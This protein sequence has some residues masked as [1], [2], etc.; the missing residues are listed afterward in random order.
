MY[1]NYHEVEKF[2]MDRIK[3]EIPEKDLIKI[4]EILNAK[5]Q[6]SLF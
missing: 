3:K 2:V 5:N 1:G 4:K 6:L